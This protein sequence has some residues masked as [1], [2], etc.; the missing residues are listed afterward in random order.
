MIEPSHPAPTDADVSN[1]L[2]SGL[3]TDEVVSLSESLSDPSSIQ[4]CDYAWPM[5][6]NHVHPASRELA[7]LAV[8]KSQV[9]GCLLVLFDLL[10]TR[11]RGK[12]KATA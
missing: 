11:R 2:M 6:V 10:G 5:A 8:V 4:P 1:T 3:L 9:F 7:K 12:R